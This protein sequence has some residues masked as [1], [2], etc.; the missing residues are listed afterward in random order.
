MVPTDPTCNI[1]ESNNR[2]I[3]YLPCVFSK[4][5]SYSVIILHMAIRKKFHVSLDGSFG[6]LDKHMVLET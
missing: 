3:E 2:W 4:G 5:N 1:S 6:M